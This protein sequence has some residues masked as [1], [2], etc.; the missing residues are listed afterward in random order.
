MANLT[1]RDVAR[2]AG[3]HSGTVSRALNPATRDRVS[4]ET[5]RRIDKAVRELGYTP[6][7]I[8]RSLRTSK[9]HTV[10]VVIPDLTNPLFPPMVRGI[11]S[12]LDEYG[13]SPLI[14]STDDDPEREATHISALLAR[15]VDGLIVGTARLGDTTFDELA[16]RG[17]RIALINRRAADSGLDSVT[18]D[19]DT[20]MSLL[21]HHLATLGHRRL[22]CLA[23]PRNTSTAVARLRGFHSAVR[24]EGLDDDAQLVVECASWTAAE[25]AARFAEA[26]DGGTPFTAVVA[27]TDLVAMGC[28]DVMAERGLSCPDDMS[29][30]GFNDMPF[31]NRLAPPLT[32][33][34]VPQY[35]IGREG[36][37]MLMAALGQQEHMPRTVL[38]PVTLTVRGSTGAP[39]GHRE[40]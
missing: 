24:A 21:I 11:E 35:E 26:L 14:V 19:D 4:P 27:A 31:V 1:L 25:G 15:Q 34:A 39:G 5:V 7:P 28:Y 9:S 20:G 22:L 30:A 6:N 13:Y 12:V 2:A 32:T 18:A 16:A 29:I 37:Q 3:V 23:G 8:A 38:L 10:G 33:V 17:T 36:A 40:R